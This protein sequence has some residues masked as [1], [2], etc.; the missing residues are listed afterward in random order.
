MIGHKAGLVVAIEII[1]IEI[2]GQETAIGA[3]EE[4]GFDISR[5]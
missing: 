3:V 5:I 4:I 2:Q 1:A